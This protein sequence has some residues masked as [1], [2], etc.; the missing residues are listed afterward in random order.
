MVLDYDTHFWIDFHG[1]EESEAGM[2]SQVMKLLFQLYEPL[3]GEM[4]ILQ[5]HPAA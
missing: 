2:W 3:R 4:Y 5:H 1:K